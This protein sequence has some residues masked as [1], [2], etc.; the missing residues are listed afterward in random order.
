MTAH[1][2]TDRQAR[3]DDLVARMTL[4]E[5]LSQLVG[6]WVGADATGAGVAPHQSEMTDAGL[7]W[8]E[9]IA[10]G[11]G[12]LTRPF[13]SAPVDPVA[14][15]RSLAELHERALVGLQSA[16]GF[17]EGRPLPAGW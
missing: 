16:A 5:K 6:L 13:G 12:Q 17:H 14:G 4:D 3:V 11:L 15:A 9:V 1:G 8:S 2:P 7:G 10:G